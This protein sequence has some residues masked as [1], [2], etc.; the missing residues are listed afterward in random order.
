[1]IMLLAARWCAEG[2]RLL[3]VDAA[4]AAITA[5]IATAPTPAAA[6]ATTGPAPAA[7]DA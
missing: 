5:A 7:I 6:A 1:M 4:T 2:E 3:F